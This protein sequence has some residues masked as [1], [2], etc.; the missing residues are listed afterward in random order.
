[1][2]NNIPDLSY[3]KLSLIDF[4]KESHPELL[5]DQ[6]FIDTRTES[7]VEAYEQAVKN[8]SNPIEAGEQGNEV[9]F[10]GL[11]FSKY[12]II[13][14]IMWNEFANTIPQEEV[15]ERAITLL[16][17]CEPVFSEYPLSDNFANEPEFEL[18]YTELTGT[19][20]LYL[21]EHEL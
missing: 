14:N 2:K 9:L 18:L 6:E 10:Q 12:D 7:A 3:Y 13:V 4:L 5:S 19:I 8:G 20:A 21:E 11:H 17:A 1:M 16:P 15:K